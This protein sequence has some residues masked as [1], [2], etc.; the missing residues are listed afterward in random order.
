MSEKKHKEKRKKERDEGEGKP[1]DSFADWKSGGR[2]PRWEDKVRFYALP[3]GKWVKIRLISKL[4][5][6][7][8]HWLKSKKNK[9]FPVLCLNYNPR[10]NKFD[11]KVCPACAYV[12]PKSGE[13]IRWSRLAYVNIIPRAV[14]KKEKDNPSEWRYGMALS[15][16][17]CRKIAEITELEGHEPYDPK[18]GY[19]LEILYNPAAD[20]SAQY[21]VQRGE[22]T[23][24]SEQERNLE[25]YDFAKLVEPIPAKEVQDIMDRFGY[26]GSDDEGEA[27]DGED[28]LSDD[29][30]DA[31][32]EARDKDKKRSKN[33][34]KKDESDDKSD[35]SD[36]DSSDSS[37]DDKSDSSDDDKSDSSDD[38]KSDSSD[39][40]SS[41][42]SDDDSSDSSDDDSS[43][44][45]DDDKSD[46][47]DDDSS[48]SSDDDSS[49]SSDDDSSDSSDDDKSDSSDDDSSDSSDDD[50]GKATVKKRGKKDKD[51]KKADDEDDDDLGV[52]LDF[53]DDD[54]SD[55]KDKKRKK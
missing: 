31:S 37:D 13:N 40:D 1:M 35:S 54:E 9:N 22:K 39:D 18:W 24:L 29:S 48:D 44:S 43:D 15:A 50:K 51:K 25:L 11:K 34:A 26:T 42:S 28:D 49:D 27:D 20:P 5:T 12:D 36:D 52:D 2:T 8:R 7:V 14:Q 3:P 45:S 38:D 47:S 19:D 21:N 53:S 33:K 4:Y 23:K 55:K 32:D 17:V 6:H 10:I 41:D 46:S 30:N 16:M